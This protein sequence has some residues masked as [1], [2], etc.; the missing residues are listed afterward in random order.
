MGSLVGSADADS[1]RALR[2]ADTLVPAVLYVD[3][4]DKGLS[5]VAHRA[6][7]A[8]ADNR[9]GHGHG[10]ATGDVQA[11]RAGGQCCLRLRQAQAS[12]PA[13]PAAKIAMAPG[14]GT[15]LRP[16]A[17]DPSVWP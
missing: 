10:G 9:L 3:E 1:R 13:A 14:S 8:P 16:M 6:T 7:F 12:K 4:T 15:A 2:I 5:G 17:E 11:S